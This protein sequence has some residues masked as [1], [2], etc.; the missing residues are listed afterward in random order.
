MVDAFTPESFTTYF[1]GNFACIMV[2]VTSK[3]ETEF[4][5]DDHPLEFW[6]SVILGAFY[7]FATV[8]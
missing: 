8:S 3:A 4:W 5:K 2:D 6:R 7:V 1:F